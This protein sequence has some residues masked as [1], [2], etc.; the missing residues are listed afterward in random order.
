MFRKSLIVFVISVFLFS[1]L[2]LTEAY[3]SKNHEPQAAGIEVYD[4]NGQYLGLLASPPSTVYVPSLSRFVNVSFLHGAISK[5]EL[6]FQSYDCTG[7][8]YIS[9]Y[10]SHFIE[11]SGEKYYTGAKTVPVE[12]EVHSH[13]SSYLGDCFNYPDYWYPTYVVPAE[14][15]P[16]DSLPFTLP[17][18]LPLE[19][20]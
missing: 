16:A 18:A 20:K 14:E 8:P 9:A 4:A 11:K 13:L 10:N 1:A 7:I 6:Y 3:A 12:I 5:T 19:F 2:A 15:V 17:V